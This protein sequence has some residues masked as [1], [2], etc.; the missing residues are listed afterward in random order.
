MASRYR[1]SCT[2]VCFYNIYNKTDSV[3]QSL[4]KMLLWWKS[5]PCML[6]IFLFCSTLVPKANSWLQEHVDIHLIKCETV[7]KKVCSINDVMTENP[8]FSPSGSYAIYV[9]GLR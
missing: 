3:P 4:L 7:E 6:Q 1:W 8:L 5:L 2:A 9:K